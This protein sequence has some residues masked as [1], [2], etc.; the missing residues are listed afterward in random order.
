MVWIIFLLIGGLGI[1]LTLFFNLKK[2]VRYLI[3]QIKKSDGQYISMRVKSVD[4]DIESLA[5]EVNHLYNQLQQQRVHFEQQE[6]QLRQSITNVSHDLRTPLT[7][8]KGYVQ[9]VEQES[10]IGQESQK[11]IEIIKRRIENLQEL[12]NAF[13]D[14][15]RI[16]ENEYPF[17]YTTVKLNEA[18]AENLVMYYEEF[19]AKGVEPIVDI[20]ENIPVVI[21]DKQVINRIFSNIIANMLKHGE[22]PIEISL[23]DNKQ[24]IIT[25]F[26]NHT[27]TV[28]SESVNRLFDRFYSGDTSRSGGASGVGLSITKVFVEKLGHKIEASLNEDML[29]IRIRWQINRK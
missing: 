18:L 9:L 13:Y 11:Y 21:T 2:E 16:E 26:K 24:E 8:I 15:S 4:K 27:S 5:N 6:K 7:S 29:C 19:I 28:T 17:Q 3:A 22:A 12:I 25:E 14:L 10:S 23:Y 1:L 20:K